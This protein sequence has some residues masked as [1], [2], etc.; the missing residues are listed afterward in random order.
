[1]SSPSNQPFECRWRP[2][3]LLLALYLAVQALA[4]AAILLSAAPPWL[5]FSCVLL[6]LAHAWYVLPRGILLSSPQAWC[7][8]RHEE[9]G[10]YLWNEQQGWQSVQ[11][12]PDSLALPLVVIL[13]FR[14]SGQRFASS[15]CV[16]RDSLPHEQHR[17]LRVRLKFS[18]RRWMAPE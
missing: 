3:G 9:S 17:R 8:L 16:P 6:G 1:M 5:Q 4:L 18:R 14:L 13:R 15:V 2:S 7:G 11:L 10:W 12:L